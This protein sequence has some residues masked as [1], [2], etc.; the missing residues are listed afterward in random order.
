MF[1]EF[2]AL[3]RKKTLAYLLS[4]VGVAAV[5]F[6]VVHCVMLFMTQPDSIPVMM[7]VCM[8]GVG[9]ILLLIMALDDV[10]RVYPLAVRMSV[11]R[12]K[13]TA[14]LVASHLLMA[15]LYYGLIQLAV[16]VEHQ[17]VYGLW[18]SMHPT[19]WMEV[20]VADMSFG[21][22]LLFLVCGMALGYLIG[23]LFLSLG[24]VLGGF[25]VACLYGGFILSNT[26]G[27]GYEIYSQIPLWVWGVLAVGGISWSI[28]VL[29]TAS[30][31]G[32]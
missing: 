16:L 25:V 7:N 1:I 19:L 22:P 10:N 18:K 12:R 32:N 30:I 13:M 3:Q 29:C 8:S 23:A 5:I 6:A 2:L 31:E 26:L 4:F 27:N 11:P 21:A 28:W 9:T 17:L 15:M 14:Y 24:R 20:F